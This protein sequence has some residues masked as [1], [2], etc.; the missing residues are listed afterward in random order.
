MT[1]SGVTAFRMKAVYFRVTFLV[2]I[3]FLVLELA[4]SLRGKESKTTLKTGSL[5]NPF[6][7]ADI[8]GKDAKAFAEALQ[9]VVNLERLGLVNQGFKQK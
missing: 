2:L 3:T 4:G 6:I 7:D 1:K 5:E 8:L 9:A